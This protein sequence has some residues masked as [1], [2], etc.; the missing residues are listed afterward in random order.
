MI[1]KKF[2]ITRLTPKRTHE[3]VEMLY[4]DW[5]PSCEKLYELLIKS[6]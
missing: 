5:K 4:D 3:S 2:E 6:G 1:L